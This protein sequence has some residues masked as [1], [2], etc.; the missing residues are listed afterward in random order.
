MNPPASA[1]HFAG[2]RTPIPH[3]IMKDSRFGHVS[4]RRLAPS[5]LAVT[6]L[7]SSPSTALVVPAYTSADIARLDD[8]V[9]GSSLTA[10]LGS[11]RHRTNRDSVFD[12]T[13]DGCSAP[14]VGGTGRT[15]DF[16]ASCR[17]HDFAYRNYKR[18]DRETRHAG[19]WW[20][21]TMRHRIDLRFRYDMIDHCSRRSVSERVN[22]H[23][24]AE[25]F[26][27]MVRIAGGP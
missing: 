9:F 13:T 27:R 23:V 22:C 8:L 5:I 2:E 24:W 15:F 3:R 1:G 4:L 21:S 7:S 6:V 16:T 14:L 12:W 25:V 18:A 26:Y 19:S 17:R 11:A 20:N 10:F